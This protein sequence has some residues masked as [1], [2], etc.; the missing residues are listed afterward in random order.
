MLNVAIRVKSPAKR[1]AGFC[2]RLRRSQFANCP[3]GFRI[4]HCAGLHKRLH[5]C[6]H[7]GAGPKMI[8]IN[9]MVK[10]R[11]Q[12]AW[13]NHKIGIWVKYTAGDCQ[14]T[15]CSC[16]GRVRELSAWTLRSLTYL[17]T[18]MGVP[19]HRVK[20]QS[21]GAFLPNG[22]VVALSRIDR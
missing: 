20:R 18:E 16:D 7:C 15:T 5:A 11:P 3:I 13:R 4:R 14:C 21:Q 9:K 6:L 17:D 12:R 2:R 22:E 1:F 8:M 10:S 19:G